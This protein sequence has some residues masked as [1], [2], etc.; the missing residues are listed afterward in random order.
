MPTDSVA[1]SSPQ[2]GIGT[3]EARSTPASRSRSRKA[4]SS[5]RRNCPALE[6]LEADADVE[7]FEAACGVRGDGGDGVS[8][9]SELR[10]ADDLSCSAG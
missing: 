10:E 6:H 8:F 9:G 3:L 2:L 1:R 5:I 7:R 4:E